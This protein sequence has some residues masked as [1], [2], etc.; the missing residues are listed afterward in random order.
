MTTLWPLTP[1][2][3]W[4]VAVCLHSAM[5]QTQ[6]FP[7]RGNC[8][9]ESLTPAAAARLRTLD[10]DMFPARCSAD[11]KIVCSLPDVTSVHWTLNAIKTPSNTII[12]CAQK[13]YEAGTVSRC[14]A[15][16]WVHAARRHRGRPQTAATKL[17]T[18]CRTAPPPAPHHSNPGRH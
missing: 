2:C 13:L 18:S 16:R 6:L 3:W 17:R 10:N 15:G 9:A 7:V 4:P 14:L 11:R 12:N 8:W 5:F 1:G